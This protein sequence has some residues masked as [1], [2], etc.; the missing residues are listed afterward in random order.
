MLFEEMRYDDDG[1]PLTATLVDYAVPSAAELPSFRTAHTVTPTPRTIRSARRASA[2]QAPPVRSVPSGMRWSTRSRH[3]AFVTS[4]RPSHR[5]ASG[6]RCRTPQCRRHAGVTRR[7]P[8]APGR[9]GRGRSRRAVERVAVEM[10]SRVPQR[11]VE[12]LDGART[13]DRRGHDRVGQQPRERDVGRSLA[14]LGAEL[15]PRVERA[16][17]ATP[18]RALHA[19][20]R[21]PAVALAD[22]HRRAV[23]C[24]AGSTGTTPTP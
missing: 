2:S 19:V 8:R 3:S 15:L 4:T 10:R 21:A 23:R 6:R 20:A 5:G 1:N 17:A 13:D 24:P 14:E 11:A 18:P 7:R 16:R 9:R 22:R 12:L